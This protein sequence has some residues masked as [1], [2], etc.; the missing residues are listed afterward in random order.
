L[1]AD[2]TYGAACIDFR[3]GVN[4]PSDG[5]QIYYETATNGVS[6]ETS[7][8]VIRTENDADDSILLRGGFIQYQ[9][10][11][12]DGGSSNPG[13][14]FTYGGTDRMYIYSDNTTETG[15]FR[16][17]IFYD[18][19]NTGFYTDPASNSRMNLITVSNVGVTTGGAGSGIDLQAAGS[20][21]LFGTTGDGANSTIA[22]V[23]LT[24]WFGIGFA[25]SISGQACPQWQNAA[26]IDVRS[27]AFSS[28]NE[29]TAYSSDQRLKTNFKNIENPIEKIKQIGGYEFDWD[30]DKC[31]GLGFKPSNIHEH[32]V[33]AQEIQKVV[34]DAVKVAPFDDDGEGNSKSGEDYLTVKYDRLVPLLIEAIKEQQSTI[35][36]LRAEM[37]E[38][39]EFVKQSLGK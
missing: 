33:K 9:S 36:Q 16:A 26:W 30:Y 7:R 28:R 18:S 22:N 23:K 13:H 34:P 17:P 20:G 15:S 8:L 29:V 38:L 31:M 4:Y 19:N 35:D 37:Q 10:L 5:A 39:K 14:R 2:S 11:T 27:G 32:G 21:Y 3:S 6:G 12:V 25:P 24:S 1:L